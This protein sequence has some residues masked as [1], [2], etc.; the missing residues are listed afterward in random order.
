MPLALA[1]VDELVGEGVVAGEGPRSLHPQA[2]SSR[3]AREGLRRNGQLDGR[4]RSRAEQRS[5]EGACEDT[6]FPGL[7]QGAE[8]SIPL[9]DEVARE[10]V[11]GSGVQ[12]DDAGA[13]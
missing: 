10:V 9:P 6:H 7:P 3:Q 5:R 12:P 11:E 13:I 1:V 4:V 2:A 8:L